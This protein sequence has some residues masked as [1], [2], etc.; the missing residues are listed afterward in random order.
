M[1]NGLLR[2]EGK[3]VR[4]RGRPDVKASR[5]H[6]LSKDVQVGRELGWTSVAVVCKETTVGWGRCS[7]N[8][9]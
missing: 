6:G 2:Q 4:S 1:S 8:Q 3:D 9:L 7:E 5:A